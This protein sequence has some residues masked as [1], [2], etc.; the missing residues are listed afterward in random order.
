MKR[1]KLAVIGLGS[2]GVTMIQ[3]AI[4]TQRVEIVALCDT[5]D[6]ALENALNVCKTFDQTPELFHSYEQLKQ[7]DGHDGTMIATNPELQPGF[8][9]EEM[10][11]HKHILCQVPVA[12]KEEDC[13]A[14][15]K[16]VRETG[17]I[18]V[19][20]EQTYH[21]DF[22]DQWR[23]MAQDDQFGHIIFAEGEYLHYEPK[24]DWFVNKNNGQPIDANDPDVVRQP[25]FISTWRYRMMEHPILYTPHT[26][27]PLLSITG[28]RITK[29]SCI[30]TK[31]ESYATPGFAVRDLET[32]VMYNDKDT[33]FVI[34]AGFTSPHGAHAG[35]GAHW[36]Q[37]KGTKRS[38]EWFRS[39][40][41]CP[42]LFDASTNEWTAPD[43]NVI[44]H[45][46]NTM[47][48]DS[49]HGGVDMYPILE[50]LDAL[51]KGTKP[52]MDAQAGV[53]LALAAIAAAKSSELGG[54]LVDVPDLQTL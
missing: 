23:K 34:K 52:F 10:K 8:A 18:F 50:F 40:I 53:Q 43:W 15:V 32:A 24:W 26:L 36:Y 20:A 30:G 16:T 44:P 31:P 19:T 11:R 5:C 39:K 42:K 54:Q 28:G 33:V 38:V 48:T 1:V 25:D 17:C 12:F 6:R 49:G 2:M 22:I 46:D 14:I 45:S 47:I 9:V 13:F 4:K 21:W 51:Q 35:T 41:D 27:N 7:F 3:N 29:V 37:L